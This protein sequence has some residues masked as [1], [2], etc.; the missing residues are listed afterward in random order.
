MGQERDG[1]IAIYF[2][3]NGRRRYENR[4]SRSERVLPLQVH[5]PKL[6]ACRATAAGIRTGSRWLE[7]DPVRGWDQRAWLEANAGLAPLVNAALVDEVTSRHCASAIRGYEFPS[8]SSLMPVDRSGDLATHDADTHDIGPA[9]DRVAHRVERAVF[10][11]AVD[12]WSG[13]PEP[14]SSNPDA[15][16]I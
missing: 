11:P 10:H 5:R 15:D 13:Y 1:G 8:A 7:R 9:A 12:R 3:P 16:Q 2:L 6:A 4:M 14:V